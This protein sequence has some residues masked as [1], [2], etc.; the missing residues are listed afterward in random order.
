MKSVYQDKK[1][2][3]LI[4]ITLTFFLMVVLF[5]SDERRAKV[6]KESE[7]SAHLEKVFL[8]EFNEEIHIKMTKKI[9]YQYLIL[10][11]SKAGIGVAQ[12][13]KMKK[14]PLY[15]LKHIVHSPQH[16]V[17]AGSIG[18]NAFFVYGDRES[19]GADFFSYRRGNE[20]RKVRL[21][22]QNYFLQVEDGGERGHVPLVNYYREDG[23]IVASTPEK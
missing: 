12:Y 22:A 8:N 16:A 7:I 20:S 2:L 15:Q 11:K 10:Y 9:D 21:L 4:L 19:I 13:E 14:I 17:G 5:Y 18:E 3:L 23:K 6:T 1:G